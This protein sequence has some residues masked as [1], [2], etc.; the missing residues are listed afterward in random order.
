VGELSRDLA[1]GAQAGGAE[2]VWL[3]DAAAAADWAAGELRQG[4][5]V[6]VKAS[7]GVGLDRVVKRLL[8]NDAD[9]EG[10]GA[11]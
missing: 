3:P 6:L 1:A 4:D 7:R 9:I 8:G 5:V 10:L 2:S 11:H